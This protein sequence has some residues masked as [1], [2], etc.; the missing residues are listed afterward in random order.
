MP[1]YHFTAVIHI[2]L[3]EE[4]FEGLQLLVEQQPA[5]QAA[6]LSLAEPALGQ[7][8]AALAAAA[9]TSDGCAPLALLCEIAASE[10]LTDVRRA[11]HGRGG[12]GSSGVGT[13]LLPTL[14]SLAVCSE[15]QAHRGRTA[16]ACLL[17]EVLC[18]QAVLHGDCLASQDE[19]RVLQL[20][21]VHLSALGGPGGLPL[22]CSLAAEVAEAAARN[23]GSGSG[24][25]GSTG[26]SSSDGSGSDYCSTDFGAWCLDGALENWE[27]RCTRCA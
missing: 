21:D 17:L 2:L 19:S 1:P 20:S 26:D 4:N 8:P 3:V 18:L 27:V 25:G 24:N 6:M 7:P 13:S 23:G 22:L 11:S 9:S 15:M 16:Q 12:G 10:V 5:F 14:T